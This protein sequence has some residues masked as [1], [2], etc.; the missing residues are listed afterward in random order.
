MKTK[1]KL[2]QW[3]P[4]VICI[5]TILFISIFALDAFNPEKTIGQQIIDFLI[6]LIPSFVLAIFLIIAWKNEFIGGLLFILVWFSF[7]PIIFIHNY[8]MNQSV[9]MSLL[10]I[11]LITMPF[12]IA[13]ILFIVSHT[14][15]KKNI[16][17]S[18]KK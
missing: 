6:H 10:I 12:L 13:G 17:S 4:R 11:L 9:W 14:M 18:I 5:L 16:S 8:N 15:K 2:I 1:L 3:T 7:S